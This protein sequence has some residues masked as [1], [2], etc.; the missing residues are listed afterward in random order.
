MVFSHQ[1]HWRFAVVLFIFL[2]KNSHQYKR[3]QPFFNG[4]YRV[5]SLS[6]RLLVELR[7]IFALFPLRRGN[8][9]LFNRKT[10]IMSENKNRVMLVGNLGADPEIKITPT[11]RK[12]AK[13]TVATNETYQNGAGE[14][15]TETQWH[16]LVAWGK[17][18]EKAEQELQKGAEVS[19]EGKIVYRQ[20]IDKDGAKKT[21]TE[22]TALE[23]TCLSH[24]SKSEA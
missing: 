16:H 6:T 14:K 10:K 24:R 23:L 13:F 9:K 21:V 18:A 11:G 22:I 4:Y 12:V 19:L 5:K 3:L 1:L 15:V 17:L 7:C 8:N 20:Y 2:D